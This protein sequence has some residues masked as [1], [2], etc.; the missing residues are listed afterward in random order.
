MGR[1]ARWSPTVAP[2]PISSV[3]LRFEPRCFKI[4]LF[5]HRGQ[6]LDRNRDACRESR[7]L[8]RLLQGHIRR[9]PGSMKPKT[10]A[11]QNGASNGR[12]DGWTRLYRQLF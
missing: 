1:R 10:G 9:V 8:K 4:L 12:T 7:L 2:M 5:H 3:L 6:S 11:Q